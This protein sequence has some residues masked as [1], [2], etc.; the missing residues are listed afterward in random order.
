[1]RI[2]EDLKLIIPSIDLL[3]ARL[4]WGGGKVPAQNP[5]EGEGNDGSSQR[6]DDEKKPL[7][8]EGFFDAS[9]MNNG[10]VPITKTPQTKNSCVLEWTLL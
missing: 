8:S 2:L 7:N 3:N 9:T 6:G 4:L 1:M 10:N 5:T